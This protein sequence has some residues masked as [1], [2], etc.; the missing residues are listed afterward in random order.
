LKVPEKERLDNLP[1]IGKSM[2]RDLNDLGYATVSELRGADP[3]EMYESLK[4]MRG[5]HIDR[6]VLYAFRCAVYC[7]ETDDPAPALRKWWNWTDDE[8]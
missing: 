3:E 7:S 6:C 1:G 5:A 8:R 2:S 4:E